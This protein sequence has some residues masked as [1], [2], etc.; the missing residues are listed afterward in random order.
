MNN[1][2]DYYCKTSN[3]IE[4]EV[5]VGFRLKVDTRGKVQVESLEELKLDEEYDEDV[6]STVNKL[7]NVKVYFSDKTA[8]AKGER[9]EVFCETGILKI[10]K[11]IFVFF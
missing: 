1:A 9:V 7:P 4:G 6:E 5:E 8:L 3:E 2:G 10:K 11:K